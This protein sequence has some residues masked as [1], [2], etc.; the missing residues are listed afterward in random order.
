MG[1]VRRE[2]EGNG[3]SVGRKREEGRDRITRRAKGQRQTEAD[4]GKRRQ[5]Q[6]GFTEREGEE[7]AEG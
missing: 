4:G 2:T 7:W 1:V 3:E 5:R 6:R